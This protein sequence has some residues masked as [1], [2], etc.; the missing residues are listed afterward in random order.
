M[1]SKII[2]MADK[3]MDAEDQL[4]EAMFKSEPIAD[5]GFSK[6]VTKRGAKT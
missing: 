3:L 6:K 4:L 1:T 5:D 2:N